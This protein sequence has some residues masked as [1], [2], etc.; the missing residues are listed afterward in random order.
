VSPNLATT[1]PDW[2]DYKTVFGTHCLHL[3][4]QAKACLISLNRSSSVWTP[5]GH[6]GDCRQFPGDLSGWSVGASAMGGG[7]GGHGGGM[8]GG[9][10]GPHHHDWGWRGRGG[11]YRGGSPTAAP[12][13][14]WF[15]QL[16]AH[17]T[18]PCE[19]TDRRLRT[20]KTDPIPNRGWDLPTR[21]LPR[22][23]RAGGSIR[24]WPAFP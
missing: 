17:G 8:H 24:S 23:K 12:A 4:W 19:A 7:G 5:C 20:Q 3:R 10:F 6:G 18:N 9:G 11:Y 16:R 21:S 2:P 15:G 1:F 14:R 22:V 13:V